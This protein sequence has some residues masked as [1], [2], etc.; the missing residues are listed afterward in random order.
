MTTSSVAIVTGAASGIG[1]ATVDLLRARSWSVVALDRDAERLEALSGDD[2]VVTLAG[3]VTDEL[4]NATAVARAEERFGGLDAVVL[5]AGVPGSGRIDTI[6]LDVFDRTIEVNL[7][8]AM[9]GMRTAVPALRR[10]GGGSIVVTASNTGLAGEELRFPYAAA[11]AGVIN[12]CRSVAIDLG[13][14]RIRVNAVCPGPTITGMTAHLEET[15]P[16]RFAALAANVPLRRW[17]DPSEIA[18]VIVFL[19]S[20]AASFVTGVALAVDGGV[21]AGTGQAPPTRDR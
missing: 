18:E 9:L 19:A 20:P 10:R 15:D 16:Q 14:E 1:R 2:G 11:K 21:T 4:V 12:L 3:D 17:A 8:A 5:N 6:D 13:P 7:R